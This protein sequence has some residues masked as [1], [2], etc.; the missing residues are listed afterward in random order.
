MSIEYNVISLSHSIVIPLDDKTNHNTRPYV[1]DI[2][3]NDGTQ[4]VAA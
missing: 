1:V 3:A 4:L 2:Q